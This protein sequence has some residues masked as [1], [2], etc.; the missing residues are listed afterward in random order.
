MMLCYI[1]QRCRINRKSSSTRF[2]LPSFY[3]TAD[4][5][6]RKHGCVVKFSISFFNINHMTEITLHSPAT[7]QLQEMLECNFNFPS[8]PGTTQDTFIDISVTFTCLEDSYQKISTAARH[9]SLLLFDNLSINK[10]SFFFP[11]KLSL[12]KSLRLYSFF[13]FS[14]LIASQ[15]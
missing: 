1:I 10:F 7:S 4:G 11:H 9:S 3:T 13:F 15:L 14:P 2:N 8:S 6:F 12:G 5:V